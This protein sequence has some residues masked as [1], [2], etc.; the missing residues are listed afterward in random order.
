MAQVTDRNDPGPDRGGYQSF[1]LSYTAQAGVLMRVQHYFVRLDSDG[2]LTRL[3]VCALNDERFC[4][5]H[6]LAGKYWLGYDGDLVKA[7]DALDGKLAA[8]VKSWRRK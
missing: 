3:V 7:D 5:H 4:R 1:D 6:A 2:Q 8:L